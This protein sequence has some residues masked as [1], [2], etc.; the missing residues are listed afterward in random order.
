[1]CEVEGCWALENTATAGPRGF[2]LRRQPISERE[3]EEQ[4]D[5]D[6]G[7]LGDGKARC[8]ECN[9]EIGRWHGLW[10]KKYWDGEST[11]RNPPKCA[12]HANMLAEVLM[13]LMEADQR[14]HKH[15][16]L[17]LDCARQVMKGLWYPVID[18]TE[19]RLF[20]SRT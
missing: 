18:L 13:R 15:E 9:P 2:H 19:D 16:W 1:M 20:S 8:S 7:D 5:M 4:P 17:C 3:R 6:W 12:N 11:I 10:T 14:T